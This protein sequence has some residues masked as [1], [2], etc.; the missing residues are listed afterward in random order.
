MIL[1]FIFLVKL[2]V[3]S[4]FDRFLIIC[5][6]LPQSDIFSICKSHGITYADEPHS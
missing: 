1:F 5:F 2:K 6:C 4:R 3:F